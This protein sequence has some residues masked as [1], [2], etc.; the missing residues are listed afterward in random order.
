MDKICE[1]CALY[2]SNQQGCVRT[3]TRQLPTDNCSSWAKEVPV[4]ESCG[5]KFVPPITYL[6]IDETPVVLCPKCASSTNTCAMCKSGGY[7]DFQENPIGIPPM[8]QQTI[9]QGNTTM[10]G[11]VPNPERIAAT[12]ANGCPCWFDDGTEKFCCRQFNCCANHN[13]KE[14]VAKKEVAVEESALTE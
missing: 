8:V 13:L 1:T 5:G 12:C 14:F 9:R 10:V 2:A 6:M 7:C 4:C 3:Q 11:T